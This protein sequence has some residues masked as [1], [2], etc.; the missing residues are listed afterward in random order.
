MLKIF[1]RR[2]NM[3]PVFFLDIETDNSE[4]FG[5]DPFLTK[6]V[7]IQILLPNGK[8]YLAKDPTE[9]DIEKIRKI[10][11]EGRIVGAN[12]KFDAKILEA[13]FNVQLKHL[14]DIQI[15][16][17]TISG[18]SKAR[19]KGSTTYKTLVKQYCD[20]EIEKESQTTFKYGEA[21]TEAQK[22]Y[23]CNDVQYLPIIYRKQLEAIKNL[24][25]EE[26]IQTEMA[27]IPVMV[28]L[29][30]SGIYFDEKKAQELE[31]EYYRI[32]A[33]ARQAIFL[34]LSSDINLNSPK[35]LKEALKKVGIPVEST[36][37]NALIQFSDKPLIKNIIEYKTMDK[38]FSTFVKK[39]P[40]TIHPVTGR[41]HADFRQY[42][43]RAGRMSC[44][45]PNLQQQPAKDIE[46]K[47]STGKIIKKLTW[48]DVYRARPGYKIVTA[49]YN[50]MELRILTQ[51]SQDPVLIEAFQK[52][53]DLHTLTAELINHEK[54]DKNTPEGN[55]KRKAAKKINFGIPYGVSKYG[56]YH[57]LQADLIS[58]TLQEAGNMLLAHRRAYPVLH[59]Y[60]EAKE[61]EAKKYLQ[62]RNLAGRLITYNDPKIMLKKEIARRE[63]IQQG[64]IK[65]T[66]KLMP[67][68]NYRKSLSR[69]IGNNGKNNPIQSLGADILKIALRGIYD[70]LKTGPVRH[71]EKQ[72]FLINVVHDEIVLEV[73]EDRAQEIASIVKDEMEKAG[74]RYL[75]VVECPVKPEIADCW[76]K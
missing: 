66:K 51:A 60:L 30:L 76:K 53:W 13:Q 22:K 8:I 21:L 4:G 6:I 41:I 31:A 14:W 38:L 44:T 69:S 35:Q 28:W 34:D 16:E 37:R 39:L 45:K 9:I 71:T 40:K 50:Q 18:G 49:D 24:Q 58:C 75:T 36:G 3:L 32:R 54:I 62:V 48:R 74:R 15:A 10:L 47:D 23:A 68:D 25:L 19:I 27:C 52:D 72:V 61:F 12:I 11:E 64:K 5:L 57:Q 56:L 59:D 42:G 26:V 17:L 65:E 43:T 2:L 67:L 7:T 63:L 29:E 46:L 73:P 55:K 70:K 20:V 1:S 33:E